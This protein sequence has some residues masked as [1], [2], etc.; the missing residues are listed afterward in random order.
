M[1]AGWSPVGHRVDDTGLFGTDG[2]CWSREGVRLD[3]DHDD[4]LAG[5]DGAQ[6]AGDVARLGEVLGAVAAGTNEADTNEPT[7]LFFA[8]LEQGGAS[9][10][11]GLSMSLR[12]QS[13]RHLG[14]MI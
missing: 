9:S 4:V 5:L 3:G 14:S 13:C 1:S 11:T 2:E 10:R 7:T 8:L 6:D 12:I